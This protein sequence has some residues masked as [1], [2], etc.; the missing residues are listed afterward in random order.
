[1]PVEPVARSLGDGK[2]EDT[3]GGV[4]AAASELGCLGDDLDKAEVPLTGHGEDAA[5]RRRSAQLTEARIASWSASRL[6]ARQYGSP[7]TVRLAMS[8]GADGFLAGRA[9]WSGCIGQPD[10]EQAL[11]TDAAT[12]LQSLAELV[13][14]QMAARAWPLVPGGGGRGIPRSGS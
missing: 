14:E 12:R 5:F 13:D 11:R 2:P 8:E 10:V 4:L 7:A 6:G 9:V 3:E 1:S